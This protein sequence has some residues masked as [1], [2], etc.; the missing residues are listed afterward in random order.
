MAP[1]IAGSDDT[2]VLYDDNGQMYI[3][4]EKTKLLEK[5]D[6]WGKTDLK[7]TDNRYKE[8][9]K[10]NCKQLY[11]K[12]VSIPDIVKRTEV[13]IQIIKYWAAGRKGNRKDPKCWAFEKAKW[14]EEV[15]ERNKE[16]LTMLDASILEKLT[17]YFRKAKPPRDGKDALLFAEIREKLVKG[18]KVGAKTQVNIQNIVAPMSDEEVRNIER[19]DPVL[20]TPKTSSQDPS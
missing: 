1:Q 17:D 2:R 7:G 20:R 10:A 3:I 4:D 11:F 15:A 14:A 16:S 6:A 18:S 13:P 5:I 8:G 9:V 12:G 19:N